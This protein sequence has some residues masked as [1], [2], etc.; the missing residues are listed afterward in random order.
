V[1]KCIASYDR[2]F[3]RDAGYSGEAL[4][5][6]GAIRAT[7]DDCNA[8]GDHAALV[9]F[10]VGEAAKNLRDVPED[11]RKQLVLGELARMHGPAAA[12]PIAYADKDWQLED[13]TGGCYVGLL[14]PGV[15]S[16]ASCSLRTSF[17]RVLFA[18]TETAVHHVGYLEGA[19]ESGQRVAIEVREAGYVNRAR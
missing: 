16:A 12:T 17:G 6:T 18:G 15:L 13:H 8:T 3:W 7:F 10:I 5:T 1:I 11:Q 2:P 14:A 4:S 19:I 9:G